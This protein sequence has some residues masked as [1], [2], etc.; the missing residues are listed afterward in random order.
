MDDPR[1]PAF[2]DTISQR[3]RTMRAKI[4]AMPSSF[5]IAPFDKS[6]TKR[7]EWLTRNVV[8]PC[9][10]LEAA[11]LD[12]SLPNFEHWEINSIFPAESI[13]GIRQAIGDL[14]QRADGL[15]ATMQV[16][17]GQDISHNSEIKFTIVFDAL[18]DLHQHFP[19]IPLSRG[20]WD[21]EIGEMVGI[22]PAYVRRVYFEITGEDDQLNVQ[23]QDIIRDQRKNQRTLS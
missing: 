9:E 4:E 13:D 2:W 17:I 16:E 3:G 20:N 14:K 11:F 8:S 21:S 10:K 15:I 23:I 1:F 22:L 6:L 19:E 7:V 18:A 5:E 12:Q